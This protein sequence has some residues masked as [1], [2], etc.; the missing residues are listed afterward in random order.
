MGRAGCVC[1]VLLF[2]CG[3]VR[4][5]GDTGGSD[6][7]PGTSVTAAETTVTV[8]SAA[9]GGSTT[10]ADSAS[11]GSSDTSASADGTTTPVLD[12]ASPR[13]CDLWAQDCPI[14]QKCMPWGNDGGG[15]WNDT[16]CSPI[17][18]DP[19]APGE[20]C[21]V[22]GAANS[23]VDDCERGAMCW[24]VDGAT[25]IGE[26]VAL[27][28]GNEAMPSCV[29]PCA[30]CSIN[31]EGTLMLCLPVC[32]PLAA[33][34][35]PGE[36]CVFLGGSFRC[37]PDAGVRGGSPGD[38]CEF[39]N[40][41]DQ[42]NACVDATLVAGCVGASGC[43]APLCNLDAPDCSS[44]PGSACVAWSEQGQPPEGCAGAPVGVCRVP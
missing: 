3:P 11:G 15:G 7:A 8:T 37:R 30:R 24:D 25:N 23:G 21:T 12:V 22:V 13:D 5:A 35:E 1:V 42:G 17:A 44:V 16:R 9:S 2:A 43:C 10:T 36:L 40:V 19:N 33:D 14:G 28:Q 27:C 4:D 41:C 18:D 6:A 31:G 20:S 34:C 29:D 32:D 38:P 39:A 26:C